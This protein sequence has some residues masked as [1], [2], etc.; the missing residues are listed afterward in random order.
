[1]FTIRA[2]DIPEESANLSGAKGK[3]ILYTL[4][5]ADDKYDIV[6]LE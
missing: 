5:P 3:Y 1:M 4:S 6:L 2:R